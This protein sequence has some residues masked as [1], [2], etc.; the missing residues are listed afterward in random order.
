MTRTTLQQWKNGK[1]FDRLQKKKH[2][3]TMK[4]SLK[5]YNMYPEING[6]NPIS[7]PLKAK[8]AL[9]KS[10]LA[11]Q[12]KSTAPRLSPTPKQAYSIWGDIMGNE[13]TTPPPTTASSNPTTST[14][15]V[16]RVPNQQKRLYMAVANT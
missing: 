9:I 6:G 3:P 8:V 7:N 13:T 4:S 11:A 12:P 2:L 16:P 1:L 5:V 10:R 14:A 15:L